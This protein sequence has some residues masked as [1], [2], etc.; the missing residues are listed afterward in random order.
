MK[1]YKSSFGSLKTKCNMNFSKF[2]FVQGSLVGGCVTSTESAPQFSLVKKKWEIKQLFFNLIQNLF[3]HIVVF[4][5]KLNLEIVFRQKY[6]Y[7]C[8]LGNPLYLQQQQ[9]YQQQQQ[10]QQ[11]EKR[12]KRRGSSKKN[13]FLKRR[14][15]SSVQLR[16]ARPGKTSDRKSFFKFHPI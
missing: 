9:H 15:F 3:F 1:Q 8:V 14:W 7:A 11:Q 10:Q 4:T 13:L 6:H 2:L 5:R 12:E 16:T